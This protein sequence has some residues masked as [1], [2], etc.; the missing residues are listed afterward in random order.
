MK[1]Y[2]LHSGRP[3]S[4]SGPTWHDRCVDDLAGLAADLRARAGDPERQ[5]DMASWMPLPPPA[6]VS[7]LQRA[8]AYIGFPLPPAIVHV[9]SAVANGGFGPG[10][11]LVGIGG[12]RTGFADSH[13]L[14]HCEDQF[15]ILRLNAMPHWPARLFPLCDWGCGIYSCAD[16]SDPD[17]RMF[18]VFSA[19]LY[20]DDPPQAIAPAGCTFAEWLRAW[21]EGQ[22]LWEALFDSLPPA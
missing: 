2:T 4:P 8:E 13:G 14:R 18:T 9:Y 17:A 10:Y 7:D 19:A 22:D 3:I 16:A 1:P 5:T 11:G 21:A 15:A 12:G 6:S 20:D